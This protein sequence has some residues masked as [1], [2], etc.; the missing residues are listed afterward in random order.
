MHTDSKAHKVVVKGKKADPLKVCERIQKKSGKK[1]ELISP[2]PKPPEEKK[3]EKEPPKE[4]EK[5]E[6][7]SLSP[8]FHFTEFTSS[9]ITMSE[10]ERVADLRVL[11]LFSVL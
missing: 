10:R 7:V 1:A 8:S 11:K 3:E 9:Q 2:L 6:E 4:E 5:K